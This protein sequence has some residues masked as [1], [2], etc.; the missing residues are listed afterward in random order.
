MKNTKEFVADKYQQLGE[1]LSL[2][3]EA[4]KKYPDLIDL[5]IGDTDIITDEQV[6]NAAFN[7]AKA[8]YTKYGSPNGDA[9][10]IKAVVDMYQEDFNQ[11]LCEE[12]VLITASSCL[13][14]SIS[15]MAVINPGDEV[16]VFSP[17]FSLYINQIELAGG[18]PVIVNLHQEDGYSLN[19]QVIQSKITEKTK[20][21]IFNNPCNPTGVFY[22]LEDLQVIADV[23]IEHDL[24]V[25]ADEIYTYYAFG[26]KFIPIRSLDGMEERTLTLNSFSK[27]F[28]MTGWRVGYIVAEKEFLEV[29]NYINGILIY[30]VP[31]ISQRAAIKALSIREE[32]R[33]KYIQEY[34]RRVEY[35]YKRLSSMPYLEVVQPKGTFYIFP[36][37]KKT[38]MDGKEFVEYLLENCHILASPGHLFGETGKDNIRMSLTKNMDM[39]EKAFDRMEKLRF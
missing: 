17:Y 14:M 1:A 30:T 21:L 27:N 11:T 31:S 20:A 38:G 9:E 37:V 2:D 32:L 3:T 28:M 33:E 16:L 25:F 8:G 7:D 19:K 29:I 36:N 15:L 12:Q 4:L 5:S 35:A 34:K 26:E 39:L 13:G 24:L 23:A 10:L 6:I 18:V 22:G